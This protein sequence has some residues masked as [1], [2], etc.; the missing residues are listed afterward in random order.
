MYQ[1]IYIYLY[2]HAYPYIHVTYMY[3]ITY[4]WILAHNMH[5]RT[6]RSDLSGM[7]LCLCVYVHL[8][9]SHEICTH[10]TTCMPTTRCDIFYVCVCTCSMY[11]LTHTWMYVFAYIQE[12]SPT[13][14]S[15]KTTVSTLSRNTHNLRMLCVYCYESFREVA[16]SLSRF[17][18]HLLS[19]NCRAPGSALSRAHCLLLFSRTQTHTHTIH[20]HLLRR[21]PHSS[22]RNKSSNSCR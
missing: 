12:C 5:T 10:T 17:L 14:I 21:M 3:A 11:A 9:R 16:R 15:K 7:R 6:Y 13:V 1:H 22:R 20:S 19:Q 4:M 18:K 2:V 8:Y